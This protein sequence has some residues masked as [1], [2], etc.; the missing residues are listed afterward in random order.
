MRWKIINKQ[1]YKE[2]MNELAELRQFKRMYD[3]IGLITLRQIRGSIN[4][5]MAAH[6]NLPKK[7][8]CDRRVHDEL[9]DILW[10]IGKE[11]G[12]FDGMKIIVDENISGWYLK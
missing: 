9:R 7:I 4:R 3:S 10:G 12:H 8:I 2:Q 11:I 1:E 5:Y 6:P